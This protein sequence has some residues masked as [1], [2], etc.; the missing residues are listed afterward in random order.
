MREAAAN[1]SV[2]GPGEGE[3][4]RACAAGFGS[5]VFESAYGDPPHAFSQLLSTRKVRLVRAVQYHRINS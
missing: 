1:L 2:S 5:S 4:G 3:D